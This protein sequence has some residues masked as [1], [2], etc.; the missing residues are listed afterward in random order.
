M[1]DEDELEQV[2]IGILKGYRHSFSEKVYSETDQD[3]DVLMDAF[4]ITQELKAENKQYWGRELGKCWEIMVRTVFQ[5]F[6]V[7]FQEP[8][9]FGLDEPADFFCGTDAIDTKYRVG[10]GDSGTLKK[11]EA[12]GQLLTAGGYQPVFLFL[13]EDNLPA[14]ISKCKAG[15]WKILMGESTFDY[16]EEKTGFDLENWLLVQTR[17]GTLK[18]D[19]NED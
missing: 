5:N 6:C 11:F 17:R 16:I 2:L 9:R 4:G 1:L 3:D 19:R 10:S 8:K 14:A 15:G 12:Y 18:I 7:D 13:R